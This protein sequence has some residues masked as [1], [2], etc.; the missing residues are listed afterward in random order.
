MVVWWVILRVLVMPVM[1]QST[2]FAMV[3]IV[4]VMPMSGESPHEEANPGENQDHPDDVPLLGLKGMAKLQADQSNDTSQ[5]DRRE[6]VSHRCQETGAGG[7]SQRPALRACHDGEWHPVIGQNR[8][9]KS[10]R[11]RGK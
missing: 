2:R 4:M 11:A 7:T 1:V 3:V 8:V 9:K 5:D 10:D 6:H